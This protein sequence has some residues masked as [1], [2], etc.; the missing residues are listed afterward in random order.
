MNEINIWNTRIHSTVHLYFPFPPN[1]TIRSRSIYIFSSLISINIKELAVYVSYLS[2][3]LWW[4]PNL[5]PL[6][7]THTPFVPSRLLSISCIVGFCPFHLHTLCMSASFPSNQRIHF[8]LHLQKWCVLDAC[9]C[10]KCDSLFWLQQ[11][12]YYTFHIYIKLE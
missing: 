8:Y 3:W 10:I 6:T 9:L 1:Q 11:K 7:H 2:T 12:F 4:F 5:F